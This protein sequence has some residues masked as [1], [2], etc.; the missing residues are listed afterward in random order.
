MVVVQSCVA[1][2]LNL[3]EMMRLDVSLLCSFV[4]GGYLYQRCKWRQTKKENTTKR[5]AVVSWC[6]P[7]RNFSRE[8]AVQSLCT[9]NAGSAAAPK[10]LQTPGPKEQ[11]FV[12]R[13]LKM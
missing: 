11:N 4:P 12:G 6:R 2:S 7:P 10:A 8:T 5:A 13:G 1:S 3:H 9:C